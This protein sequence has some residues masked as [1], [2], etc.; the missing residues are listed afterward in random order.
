MT[1]KP[2]P[3][4]VRVDTRHRVSLGKDAP[5]GSLYLYQVGDDGVI[6]LTPA[7]AVPIGSLAVT[8]D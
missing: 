8:G 1:D 6:V 7:V 5:V 3:P 2:Q 4:I